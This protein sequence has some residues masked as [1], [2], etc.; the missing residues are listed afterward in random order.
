MERTGIDGTVFV[1]ELPVHRQV[2]DNV[3]DNQT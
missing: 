3:G 2:Q 1:I